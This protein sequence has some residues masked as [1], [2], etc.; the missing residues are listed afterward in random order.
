MAVINSSSCQVDNPPESCIISN[1]S[2]KVSKEQILFN[3]A[4]LTK[5]VTYNESYVIV[6]DTANHCIRLLD[7]D[8]KIVETIAGKCGTKGFLD[9][10]LGNNLLSSPTAL[11]LD[12][13]GNIWIYDKGNR[14]VRMLNVDPT[15]EKWTQRGVLLTMQQGVC[16]DLPSHI[17]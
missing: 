9:G 2:I 15:G 8:K 13:Y 12:E 16:N 14:Y 3:R 10:P 7:L 11:G 6:A 5:T 17:E 4:P 1:E